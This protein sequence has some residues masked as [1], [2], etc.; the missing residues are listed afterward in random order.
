VRDVDDHPIG[1][2]PFH[3]EIAVA[4]G[5]HF[6]IEPRLLLEPLAVRVL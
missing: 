1:T 5:S 4:A 3:L 6:R 2:G